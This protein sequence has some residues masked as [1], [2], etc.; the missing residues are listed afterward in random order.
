MEGNQLK[1]FGKNVLAQ[2]DFI[3]DPFNSVL[4]FGGKVQTFPLQ[5]FGKVDDLLLCSATKPL[6]QLLHVMILKIIIIPDRTVC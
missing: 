2:T 1:G 5:P 6:L 3:Q 4:E